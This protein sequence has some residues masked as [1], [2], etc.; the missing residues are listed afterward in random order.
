MTIKSSGTLAISEIYD[1][2]GGTSPHSLSEYYG[3]AAGIPTSGQISISDFYGKSAIPPTLQL[4]PSL[5]WVGPGYVSTSQAYPCPL[6]FYVKTEGADIYYMMYSSS[7]WS[8]WTGVPTGLSTIAY[9]TLWRNEG[10]AFRISSIYADSTQVWGTV[11]VYDA[12][13]GYRWQNIPFSFT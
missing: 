2:F 13:Y 10:E 4:A 7:T 9:G 3:A 11:D 8:L 6:H 12:Y 5:R 1:E